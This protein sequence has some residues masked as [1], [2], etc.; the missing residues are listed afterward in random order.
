[1]ETAEDG[2]RPR[3]RLQFGLDP[4]KPGAVVHA[5]VVHPARKARQ[6]LFAHG[7]GFL[8]GFGLRRPEQRLGRGGGRGERQGKRE[9]RR[10]RMGPF[11]VFLPLV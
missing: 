2:D 5:L 8:H 11:H 6:H 4:G 1:V 9:K 10:D 3:A 7:L